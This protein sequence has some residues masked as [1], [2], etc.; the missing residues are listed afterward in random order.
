LPFRAPFRGFLALVFNEGIG[1]R[2]RLG[3]REVLADAPA[4]WRKATIERQLHFERKTR[5]PIATMTIANAAL[6]PA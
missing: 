4:L 3:A 1:N 6:C 2:H 5:S